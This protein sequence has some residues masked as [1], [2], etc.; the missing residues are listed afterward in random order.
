MAFHKEAACLFSGQNAIA[1]GI[2][3]KKLNCWE[4]MKCG[5]EGRNGKKVRSDICP[6]ASSASGN[7]LNGGLNGGRICWMIAGTCCNRNGGC[8]ARNRKS[9][10]VSCE[11]RS[12]VIKQEGLQSVCRTTGEFL[13]GV[14]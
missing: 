6:V 14:K 4:F 5:R 13:T 12:M 11:F 10:C 3:D 2:Q 8:S 1:K 9:S 7:G